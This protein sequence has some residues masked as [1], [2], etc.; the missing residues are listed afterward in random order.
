MEGQTLRLGAADKNE[1]SLQENVETSIEKSGSGHPNTQVESEPDSTP[2]QLR[3]L[4]VAVNEKEFGNR[5]TALSRD[6]K[7]SLQEQGCNILFLAMGMVEW[8][9]TDDSEERSLAP[10]LFIP[11]ALNRKGLTSQFSL[12]ALDEEAVSNATLEQLC[13]EQFR[14]EFPSFNP[15]T[16]DPDAFFVRVR[17]AI[18]PLKWVFREEVH[19]G[20]YSFATLAMFRDLDPENWPEGATLLDNPLI[21]NLTGDP[22]L[23][24]ADS[25]AE[26]PDPALL[27]QAVDPLDCYQVLD[28]DSSQQAAI[29]AAKRGITMVIDGPP[30][31]G[32]S[33]TITNIIAECLADNKTVLFVAAKSAALDVVKRRLEATGLRDFILDLHDYESAKKPIFAEIG[34]VLEKAIESFS[35]RNGDASEL[36]RVRGELNSYRRELH[37]PLGRLNCSPFEAMAIA[38]GLHDAPETDCVIP[39]VL[40]WSKEQLQSAR[41]QLQSLDLQLQAVRPLEQ[42]PWHGVKLARA[43]QAEKQRLRRAVQ[44]LR[45]CMRRA[46]E[47]AQPLALQLSQHVP[48][49]IERYETLIDVANALIAFP[50]DAAPLLAERRWADPDPQ[51]SKLLDAG[52]ERS[53]LCKSWRAFFHDAAEAEPWADVLKRRREQYKSLTRLLRPSWYLDG[54][55]IARFTKEGKLPSA[56][57]QISSL[58]A[59]IESAS[60]RQKLLAGSD[61]LKQRF[62]PLW[63]GL[64]CDWSKLLFAADSLQKLEIAIA[65]QAIERQRAVEIAG[66]T[67]RSTLAT[68]VK[69]A[70]DSSS[71]VRDAWREWLVAIGCENEGWSDFDLATAG[72]AKLDARLEQLERSG[73]ALDDWIDL[74]QS[75]ARGLN[76]PL[77]SFIDS[78]RRAPDSPHL[79][80]LPEVFERQFY[81]LWVEKAFDQRPALAR[82]RAPTHE[83]TI[84]RFRDLDKQWITSTQTRLRHKLAGF[85]P[86]LT[87]K[88]HPESKIGLVL[89][90]VRKK[91]RFKPLRRLFA[92]AGEVIL[93]V[94][95]CLMMSPRSV[96]KHLEPGRQHFD[97]VIFDEASQITPADALGAIA[98][99]S[100]LILVGDERQLPPTAFFDAVNSDEQDDEEEDDGTVKGSD[101]ESILSWGIVRLPHRMALCWHYRSRHSSLIDFSNEKFYDGQLRIFPSPQI[102][103]EK[104]GLSFRYINGGVYAR[105]SKR[106]N[107]NPKEAEIVA[108]AVI[109]H[110][111]NMPELSLCV[112]T[113]NRPQQHLIQD[114]LDELSRDCNDPRVEQFLNGNIPHGEPFFVKNLENIQGDERDVVMLSIT[115]GKDK[116]GR[117]LNNFGLNQESGWRRLNVL[118]TR[119]RKQCIVF[120]SIRHD[121]IRTG[122]GSP[123]GVIALKDYLYAAEHGKL[124]DSPVA[125][126]GHDSEFEAAVCR[127]LTSRGW[128]VDT[129]VGCAGFAIDLAVVDPNAPGRYLLG[130]ECDGATYHSSATAR[131]RDR[132]RQSVLEGLG[133]TIYRIWSTD[134]FRR[135][136]STLDRLLQRLDEMKTAAAE[137]GPVVT[138]SDMPKQEPA[139]SVSETPTST[140]GDSS[141]LT[142][143]A[144]RHA[145]QV[146][147]YES[148]RAVLSNSGQELAEIPPANLVATL[149]KIVEVEGPIHR[150]ELY[151]AVATIHDTRATR[152]VRGVIDA[153]TELAKRTGNISLGE[154]LFLRLVGKPHILI[155]LRVE[156]CPVTDPDLI[157][158]EEIEAAVLL[159][160]REQY[161]LKFDALPEAVS[162]VFG[163]LRTGSRIRAAVEK[164]MKRLELAGKIALDDKKF[165]TLIGHNGEPAATP[166]KE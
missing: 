69:T 126:A 1:V 64:D 131:D 144:D 26:V 8:R 6:A 67:D 80:K 32:K 4:N 65:G 7:T 140:G 154:D 46:I 24:F 121:D 18:S 103:R 36:K 21:R 107:N 63:R 41:E 12:H 17:E 159:V 16:D 112:G 146:V 127:E 57:D 97:V 19:L 88:A 87:S 91:A 54:H 62:G 33:Q 98:R 116:D 11:V 15:E 158:P 111:K 3:F 75:I 137:Q 89:A 151:R 76:S 136:Q 30:G 58:S 142:A 5:L 149:Q 130:I 71:R 134:W 99:G 37:E 150:E 13:R 153:A 42:H 68:I 128:Q 118:V 124:V 160:L 78:V 163:F 9:P 148:Y 74:S 34:R 31:T 79:G 50:A 90:E 133:W 81:R 119:A 101:L 152:R 49:S 165:S 28:A 84:E 157:P 38:V 43:G 44:D 145:G 10:A 102:G 129:Q 132:L 86:D 138:A 100:Q 141:S 115:Y 20:L 155:R 55:R 85:R 125:G 106:N 83:A 45:I 61:L 77:G 52:N 27:D 60:L 147:P 96:A 82:F 94:K 47:A 122:P 109:E 143:S 110:A 166:D 48:E 51:V 164:A 135:P 139:V 66:T 114:R 39:E 117:L 92:E 120:S 70:A 59:V 123:R 95:P 35:L 22:S 14:T 73:E 25:D 156:P 108:A 105:G 161:G 93:A 29:L 2:R 56:N 104:L 162:H 72:F 40:D 113:L 53:I 23:Q